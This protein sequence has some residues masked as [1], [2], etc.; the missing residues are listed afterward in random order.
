[1][2]FDRMEERPGARLLLVLASL[3]IVVAGLKA[4]ALILVPFV[5]ALFLAVVS[6]PVMFGLRRK[7]VWEPAAI[8]LTILLNALLF[9][10]IILLVSQALW[11]LNRE[12]PRYISLFQGMYG[13][14]LLELDRRGIPATTYLALQPLDPARILATARGVFE[15]VARVLSGALLVGVIMV[16]VLAEATV[17][18]YKFQAILGG[19]RQSRMRITQIVDEV[20]VYLGLK[21]LTSLTTGVG[22]TLLCMLAG[23]DFPVLLGVAAFILHFVPTLGA[24]VA[25]IPAVLLALILHGGVTALV[26]ALGYLGISTVIGSIIDPHIMGHRLGL[27]TLVVVLSLLFW[28]WLWG[29]VGALLSVPLTM[30]SK[31]ALQNVPDLRWI[32]ILLD[33]VPPQALG[34]PLRAPPPEPAADLAPAP[35]PVP[36]AE[37]VPTVAATDPTGAIAYRA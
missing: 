8:V 23:L 30:V 5:L 32:A 12:L 11:E 14:W 35:T 25:A 1:M 37:A 20:Q 34:V 27:S 4:A 17:F 3:V 21:F 22:V 28:G 7:G 19:N 15:A 24:I 31:I 29:P 36:A 13:G 26:V 10:L 9:G 16:F 6:M 18:P 33:K 2:I